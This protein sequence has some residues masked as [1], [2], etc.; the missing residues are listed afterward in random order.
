MKE[1]QNLLSEA[2]AFFWNTRNG[3]IEKQRTNGS[4]DTGNRWAVTGWQQMNGFLELF[5]KLTMDLWVPENCIHTKK[6]S[7][8]GY[9]RPSK[10]WDLLVISPSGKLIACLELKSQVGSFW[11]NF[12]NRTEEALWNAVDIWTSFREN[13]FPDQ[14]APFVWYVMVAEKTDI[15]S[16]PRRLTKT[17]FPI[18]KEFIDTSYLDRYKIFCQKLMRERHYTATALI[19]TSNINEY[20]DLSDDTSINSFLNLYK[21]YISSQL[22]DFYDLQDK[23]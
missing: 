10:D 13:T 20:W 12:N 8:P 2:I 4:V 23:N 5:K 3:Q 16:S 18:L 19:W 9:F 15:S 17:H 6:N 11:N 1:Y 21:A 14:Q 7:L 22:K